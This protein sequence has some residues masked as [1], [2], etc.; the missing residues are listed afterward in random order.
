MTDS[1]A[2]VRGSIGGTRIPL[3][4]GPM[5]SYIG[6]GLRVP[7]LTTIVGAPEPG[8]VAAYCNVQAPIGHDPQSKLAKRG[9]TRNST[10]KADSLHPLDVRAVASEPT[11][12]QANELP[13]SN[14]L[15]ALVLC[16]PSTLERFQREDSVVRAAL[17]EFTHSL[18]VVIARL[19]QS[20]P[21]RELG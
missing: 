6:M 2:N 21:A 1:S 15:C 5:E 10:P 16:Y 7:F 20:M 8:C 18:I 13:R 12:A 4:L 11:I 19:A 9:R 17:E 3:E 14:Q